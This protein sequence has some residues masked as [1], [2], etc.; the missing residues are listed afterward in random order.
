MRSVTVVIGILCALSSTVV[1]QPI[2]CSFASTYPRQYVAYKT[3][4]GDLVIDGKLDDPA[5]QEVRELSPIGFSMTCRRSRQQLP[6][7]RGRAYCY[8]FKI[9]AKPAHVK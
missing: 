7:H 4:A 2:D 5:W 9:V 3:R 8:C 6:A 1:C